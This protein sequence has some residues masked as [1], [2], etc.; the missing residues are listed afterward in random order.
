MARILAISSQVARGHVGLSAIVPALQ[1]MGHEVIALPTILLSN[2]PGH[3]HA[4]GE[5]VAP[6][7]LRRMLD[8][9]DKN[10]WLAE[11]DAVMTGYLPSV[12]HVR[13]A[14]EAVDRLR[15]ANPK[16]SYLCDPVIGDE[17]KG[18]YI[19]E[20]AAHAIRSYLLPVA[21][22]IK[23]NIF[24]LGWLSGTV[25]D[26]PNCVPA[27]V[28]TLARPTSVVTSVLP[29]PKTIEIQL[30]DGDSLVAA[31][32]DE[33]RP[34]VP[35]GTGDLLGGLYL[36]ALMGRGGDRIAAFDQ[37]HAV[38]KCTIEDSAGASELVLTSALFADAKAQALVRRERR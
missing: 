16:M 29:D 7:L 27:A 25:I 5:R 1:A 33:R 28:R 31:R 38:L 32:A 23:L 15:A 14:L 11:V 8:A 9:L 30:Y 19:A 2:H 26:S 3:A 12:E 36:G 20:A 22:V 21:D 35:N 17:P 34:S 10:G 4:A 37:A 13:F 6:D 24:E 18:V